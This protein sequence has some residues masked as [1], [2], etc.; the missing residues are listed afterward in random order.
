MGEQKQSDL[1]E[2]NA[3]EVSGGGPVL[4]AISKRLRAFNKKV[5]RAEEIEAIKATGKDINE[6]Q[7]EVL[8]GKAKALGV[9]AELEHLVP[10]LKEA[11]SQEAESAVSALLSEQAAKAE[12]EKAAAGKSADAAAEPNGHAT[13]ASP[14]EV[15]VPTAVA[16]LVQLAYF[17]QVF[18]PDGGFPPAHERQVCVD[19]DVEY[20]AQ[21]AAHLTTEDLCSIAR[22]GQMLT[23]RTEGQA[24]SHQEALDSG[25][26][27]ALAWIARSDEQVPGSQLTVSELAAKFERVLKSPYV[28]TPPTVNNDDAESVVPLDDSH[29]KDSPA[30]SQLGS[31]HGQSM[32]PQMQGFGEPRL[33]NALYEQNGSRHPLP[34]SLADL[35]GE[36]S[37]G[38][39]AP[40]GQWAASPPSHIAAHQLPHHAPPLAE[41]LQAPV[42]QQRP[43]IPPAEEWIDPSLLNVEEGEDYEGGPSSGAVDFNFM[44]ESQVSEEQQPPAVNGP[45]SSTNTATAAPAPPA[46]PAAP[47]EQQGTLPRSRSGGNRDSRGR[48]R[49]RGGRGYQ[50]DGPR[51]GR[52]DR[53]GFAPR[54]D[55]GGRGRGQRGARSGRSQQ[56]SN[57]QQPPATKS[58]T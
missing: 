18:N 30:T 39:H 31:Y 10:L 29:A 34:V 7:E 23:K 8:A 28:S 26:R 4:K 58:Q 45:T 48:Y 16:R 35:A 11:A 21:D 22:L 50:G 25:T 24:C 56:Q 1:V 52:G 6:Q 40:P 2:K 9:I 38:S 37:H 54:G 32:L 46:E 47:A 51:G 20:F 19:Y 5:K 43:H 49:G 27:L 42:Q 33:V 14:A 41:P 13:S 12:A 3:V 44:V 17:T 57:A 15:D 36:P 53:G 55:R